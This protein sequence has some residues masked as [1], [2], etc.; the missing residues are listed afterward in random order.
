MVGAN[1]HNI[2]KGDYLSVAADLPL[3]CVADE[4]CND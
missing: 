1:E 3:H 2:S 4:L